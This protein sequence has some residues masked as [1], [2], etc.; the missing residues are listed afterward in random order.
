V[1]EREDNFKTNLREVGW[2][3]MDWIHLA[4]D[5]DQWWVLVNTVMKL[6]VS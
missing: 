3:G 2:G 5:W 1:S 6:L 4:Q